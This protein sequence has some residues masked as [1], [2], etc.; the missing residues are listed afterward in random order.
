MQTTGA[1]RQPRSMDASGYEVVDAHGRTQQVIQRMAWTPAGEWTGPK[2]SYHIRCDQGGNIVSIT[3]PYR[4]RTD[5]LEVG[6]WDGGGA[7]WESATPFVVTQQPLRDHR[8]KVFT[9][10]RKGGRTGNNRTFRFD[11]DY[12]YEMEL[13][14]TTREDVDPQRKL[15]M[16]TRQIGTPGAS[17]AKTWRTAHRP[18][19]L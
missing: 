5:A 4:D 12:P 13:T 8:V 17:S 16:L 19:R 1:G 7:R 14:Y 18:S 3:K 10:T 6:G 9:A 2:S 15:I 11:P